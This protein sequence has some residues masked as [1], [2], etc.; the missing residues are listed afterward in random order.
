MSLEEKMVESGIKK[1][2]IAD[3]TSSNLEAAKEYF[4]SL[5][6]YGIKTDYASSA[7]QA[8]EKIQAAYKSKEKYSVVISDMVM[9]D[10]HSGLQ[11]VREG[12]KHQTFSFIA[13]GRNYHKS[14]RE[15]HGPYTQLE[16]M[17]GTI[18]GKKEKPEVW[19]EIFGKTLEH[20]TGKAKPT[21][22]ALERYHKYAGKP[23]DEIADML[24]DLY[25]SSS[26]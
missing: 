25:K 6:K 10:P 17:L 4:S 19:K 26:E 23:S 7:K 24:M 15:A 8:K 13:T 1:I 16:P 12:F 11:V 3:D 9:E 14:D 5:E 22:A 2:L 21:I 18:S 20:I